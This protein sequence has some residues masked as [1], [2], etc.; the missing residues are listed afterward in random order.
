LINSVSG[1]GGSSGASNSSPP[2][3]NS[4][5]KEI[6][7]LTNDF[8]YKKYPTYIQ[9]AEKATGLKINLV[10][11]PINPNDRLAKINSILTS[12]DESIDIIS[13]NDEM[14]AE[15]RK[16]DFLEPLQNT[17]MTEDVIQQFSAGYIQNMC[18]FKGNIFSVPQHTEVLGLW[19]NQEKLKA[20]GMKRISSKDDFMKYISA[21]SSRDQYGYGG[22]WDKTYVFNEIGTFVNLFGGDYYNWK[23]PKSKEAVK[24]L[25][26]MVKNHQTPV[27]QTADQYESMIQ[28]FMDG[29]YGCVFMWSSIMQEL[30]DSGKYGPDKL[31]MVAMPYFK[32]N[33]AYLSTWHF[34]LNK[35]SANKENALLFLRY[36]AS[37]EGQLTEANSLQRFPA[38][39]DALNDPSLRVEGLDVL[40]EYLSNSTLHARPIVSQSM[41][42]ISAI[43]SIFQRY[44]FDEITLDEFCNQAQAYVNQFAD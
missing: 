2:S 8:A 26:N 33:D 34:V 42:F 32:T 3:S 10:A 12:G 30:I 35:A 38:R 25:H 24:F 22:A 44:I 19:V 18:E 40:K 29:D 4:N 21:Y 11:E 36:A 1:C 15:F 39:R 13:I 43:G 37:K 31:H 7:L 14:L 17:V 23:N 5:R 28:K 27:T 9:E 6:T 41:D 16:T 20:I